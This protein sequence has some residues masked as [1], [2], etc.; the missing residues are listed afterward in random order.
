MAM[1]GYNPNVSLLP[2]GGGTIQAMSGGGSMSGGYAFS[3]PMGYNAT[4]SV[5]PSVNAQIPAYH[6][7]FY[8]QNMSGGLGGP[9]T[10]PI[11]SAPIINQ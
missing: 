8:T 3:P 2:Q 5:L 4:A 9:V 10:A 7:G 1:A 6:G 11:A